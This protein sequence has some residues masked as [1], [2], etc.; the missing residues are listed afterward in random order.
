MRTRLILISA[1]Y[2]LSF[3][4]FAQ[5]RMSL[6]QGGE[7]GQEE[8]Q[9]TE[10]V[11]KV[12]NWHLEDMGSRAD[13]VPVDT[14]SLGFQV[15]N[16][17]YKRAMSNV[18]LGNIGAAWMPAM[19]SQMP[20]SRHFL[21][22]ES[23]THVFTQPEEW[24]YYNSTTPYTN[25]YY[26][27]SGPKARS[28]EVLGVLFSQ[29][30]NRKWNVG[31]SYDLTSS[32]GKY[33]AQKV[34]N[35]N[36]R[37]FSSYSGKVYEIYGNYIYSKAD[38]L[39]NGGIVDEDHILNPEKY[40]WGRSNNIPVQFYTASNRIDNNRLY[41]S[42]ALKIGKIAV[43]QG[44][45]G[46]RQTPLATVLHSLDIDRSRRLHR[47]D[48]LAR[49]YNE[50][51]GNFF[52]SNIYADTTMTRDSL[53]Y[54]RVANTV[55]LK[56]NEEANTLLRFGLRAFISNEIETFRVQ[57]PPVV[58]GTF[59]TAP[60]YLMEKLR[61]STT[62]VGGQI[63]KNL[64]ETFRWNAGMR[65]YFQG[66]RVGD[67]EITGAAES[68][69]R[70]GRDT[71]SVYANGGIYLTSPSYFEEH[72]Y[73][74][75]FRWDNDFGK[76]ETM[77]VAGGVSIPTRRL[78]LSAEGRFIND[79]VF[80]N[81]EALPEQ[82]SSFISLIEFRLYKHFILARRLHSRNTVL[83]QISSHQEIVPLPEFSVFSSN[84]YEN[85]LFK[86]LLFQFGFDFRYNSL[87]YAPA[88]MPAL[89]RFYV[90]NER[91]VG[92][93]PYVD[94]FLNMQLKRAR[95]FIKLDH[96]SMG[97]T[98]NQYFHTVGYPASPRSL[99][100]GVSWNFYD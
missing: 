83:Y 9:R 80:W 58:T 60:E 69:F 63:F 49:M 1:L 22:T 89:S 27:Y 45:S 36:F 5:G 85:T 15:H 41:I 23:Y 50:S 59:T 29:N 20:L 21:F 55:Q 66:Y 93:Y 81:S 76:V 78:E 72:Y 26:Q 56:F 51:E 12:R 4:S 71:A 3:S 79:Y 57:R 86:V 13:T 10:L 14:L 38:H 88:Y 2:A 82:T 73:S 34:D 39:E 52:Y 40:D 87:W 65:F 28:E 74:N 99:R 33:N 100:F 6:P 92:D 32:V 97:M 77:R 98:S 95:I 31:F 25:L 24:L 37:V 46:K 30:V 8:G 35:R 53:Y 96:L 61:Y 91:K 19:V 67:S 64:G 68:S 94:L 47:I 54:T 42:Q 62:F 70:V 11:H 84:Y 75:H 44:E 17:A 16:H 90:Q 48:E 43:S 7:P 18:Q